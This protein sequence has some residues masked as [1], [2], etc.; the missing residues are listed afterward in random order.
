MTRYKT[1]VAGE[2]RRTRGNIQALYLVTC[3][4]CNEYNGDPLR[5]EHANTRQVAVNYLREQGW[6]RITPYGWICPTC[7]EE[8]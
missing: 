6:A 3:G 1:A 8:A 4:R 7:S 2:G 5:I